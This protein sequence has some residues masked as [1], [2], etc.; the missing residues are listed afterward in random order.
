V[1]SGAIAVTQDRVRI[2]VQRGRQKKAENYAQGARVEKVTCGP[3][4]V[5]HMLGEGWRAPVG[6][7]GQTR[8]P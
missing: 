7:R 8:R 3:R 6:E 1:L 5:V 4:V 2:Q